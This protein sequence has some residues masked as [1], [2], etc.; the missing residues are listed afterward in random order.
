VEVAKAR[1]N[2]LANEYWP[3]WLNS[4]NDYE[5]YDEWLKEIRRRVSEEVASIWTGGPQ[6]LQS[7][8]EMVCQ[9]AVEETLEKLVRDGTARALNAEMKRLEAR[10][11][12]GGDSR[13]GVQAEEVSEQT[14]DIDSTLNPVTNGEQPDDDLI[15]ADRRAELAQFKLRGRSAG[16]RITDEMVAHA[17][18]LRWNDRTMVTWWK[19]CDPRCKLPHDKM[20]RSVLKKDPRELWPPKA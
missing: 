17:A 3:H 2:Y 19:R 12:S 15:A 7:W 11:Q 8:Y 18:K 5:V 9:P 6:P 10:A 13:K 16:I 1:F 4:G 20:I 14:P